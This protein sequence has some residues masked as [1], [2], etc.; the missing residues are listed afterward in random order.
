MIITKDVILE[1]HEK[2]YEY[3][4]IELFAQFQRL[5]GEFRKIDLK[6]YQTLNGSDFLSHPNI[7]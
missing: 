2:S 6:I 3:Q 7:E 1:F 4:R 5:R